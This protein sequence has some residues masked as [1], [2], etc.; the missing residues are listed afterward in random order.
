MLQVERSMAPLTEFS[1]RWRIP[2]WISRYDYT[3]NIDYMRD[4]IIDNEERIIDQY[5]YKSRNDGGTGL[6]TRSLT[7]QYNT[8]NLFKETKDIEPFQH[9]FKFLRAEYEARQSATR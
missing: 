5:A 7:A 3:D 8:F 4:W 1:P 2:F 9:F 6:G